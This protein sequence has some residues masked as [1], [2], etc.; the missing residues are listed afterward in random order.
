MRLP[1]DIEQFLLVGQHTRA[2]EALARRRGIAPDEARERIKGRLLEMP[3]V[4][5][6]GARAQARPTGLSARLAR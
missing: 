4:Q 1:D 6:G 5:G 3:V 2:I